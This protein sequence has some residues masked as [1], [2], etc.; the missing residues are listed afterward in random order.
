MNE[1]AISFS[2]EEQNTE[3]MSLDYEQ[4]IKVVTRLI[5]EY[6]LLVET[7]PEAVSLSDTRSISYDTLWVI[8]ER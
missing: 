8:I 5:D 4:D 6:K 7:E 2:I 1:N 3:N